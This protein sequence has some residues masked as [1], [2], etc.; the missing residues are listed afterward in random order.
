MLLLSTKNRYLEFLCGCKH[1]EDLIFLVAA[2]CHLECPE[3]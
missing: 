2:Y 1:F 3:M